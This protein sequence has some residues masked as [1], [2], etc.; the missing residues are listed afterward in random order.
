MS[1][2]VALYARTRCYALIGG[3]PKHY[4]GSWE[5]LPTMHT[6]LTPAPGIRYSPSSDCCRAYQGDTAA[7][8]TFFDFIFSSGGRGQKKS[9]LATLP[10]I[11]T[12]V[13]CRFIPNAF[14]IQ[15][16]LETPSVPAIPMARAVL[17]DGHRFYSGSN[18]FQQ[19]CAVRPSVYIMLR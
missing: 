5:R 3:L 18:E 19:N 13:V 2:G 6:P 11:Y 4:Q 15:P 7:L 1:S 17:I 10:S 9:N 12:P 14:S 16:Q 8:K